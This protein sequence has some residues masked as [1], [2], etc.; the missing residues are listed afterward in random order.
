MDAGRR[1]SGGR[2]RHRRRHSV[3]HPSGRSPATE[4]PDPRCRGAAGS[5]CRT[6]TVVGRAAVGSDSP[7]APDRLTQPERAPQEVS[8][9]A[10]ALVPG[11]ACE[12][13]ARRRGVVAPPSGESARRPAVTARRGVLAQA[14][15]GGRPPDPGHGAAVVAE[16]R[17]RSTSP[18]DVGLQM[19]STGEPRGARSVLRTRRGARS[20]LRTQRG[21]RH[22]RQ[23]VVPQPAWE[24]AA[25]RGGQ[26]A[27]RPSVQASS[28]LQAPVPAEHPLL[29]PPRARLWHP[30]LAW[31]VPLAGPRGSALPG[32]PCGGRG[33]LARPRCSTSGS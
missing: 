18:C 17:C 6:A 10:Q 27:R 28:S 32:R 3:G 21:A 13:L 23:P 2:E 30:Y 25:L 4:Q 14:A 29:G 7:I 31:P 33:P 20:V 9:A 19:A 11:R 8:P 26:R 16:D 12:R 24:R 15:P 1:P 22:E 5:A